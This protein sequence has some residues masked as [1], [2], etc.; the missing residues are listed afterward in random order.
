M[1]EPVP[2]PGGSGIF[3]VFSHHNFAQGI[4]FYPA[5]KEAQQRLQ[6]LEGEFPCA[7]WLPVIYQHPTAIAPTWELSPSK[8][9]LSQVFKKTL[10]A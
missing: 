3:K 9:T 4:P 8:N 6:G 7:S 10:L 1:R 5:V 2:D